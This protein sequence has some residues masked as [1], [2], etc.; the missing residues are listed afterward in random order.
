MYFF[1]WVFRTEDLGN[2]KE[3]KWYFK[4]LIRQIFE[5]VKIAKIQIK[6]NSSRDMN[7]SRLE[8]SSQRQDVALC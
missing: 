4:E 5:K 8:Q 7:C 3:I 6:S 1:S 2:N